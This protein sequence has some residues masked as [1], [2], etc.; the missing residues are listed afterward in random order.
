MIHPRLNT[1][2]VVLTA[3]RRRVTVPSRRCSAMARRGRPPKQQR[4]LT[5]PDLIGLGFL[6]AFCPRRQS[7]KS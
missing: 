7:T 2:H 4:D 5:V 1:V 3:A 6:G